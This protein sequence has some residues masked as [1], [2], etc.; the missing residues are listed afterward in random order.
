M[1]TSLRFYCELLGFEVIRCSDE[2]QMP[3][4]DWVWLRL[5]GTEIM[6]NTAY[7]QAE[8][9]RVADAQRR[10]SHQDTVLFFAC[11]EVDRTAAYLRERGVGV[12]TPRIASYGMK[13]LY[14]A[15]PD[16]YALCFQWP[17]DF[18]SAG[19]DYGENVALKR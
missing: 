7:E 9:P 13:Q 16:G 6:L 3:N 10:A 12:E 4:V 17:A 8:R 5:G 15:D 19:D 2:S 1:A 11:P 18:S 14:V